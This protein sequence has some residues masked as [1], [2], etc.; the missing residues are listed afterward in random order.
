LNTNTAIVL[1]C[2][3]QDGSYLCE[4][5]ISKGFNVIGVDQSVERSNLR[6]FQYNKIDLLEDGSLENLLNFSKP[7]QIYNLAGIT[8]LIECENDPLKAFR[9][10]T[11]LV[12]RIL[13]FI[14]NIQP[15]TRFFQAS[16]S[17]IF[18]S[19]S[20]Q[21]PQNETTICKPQNIYAVTKLSSHEAV[22]TFRDNY[23][24]K[25][26]SG[27]LYNHESSRRKGGF[28]TKK[29]CDWVL[30]HSKGITQEPLKLGNLD[31]V[32]DFGH[33]RDFVK[34]MWMMLNQNDV[35][36]DFVIGTGVLTSIKSFVSLAFKRIHIDIKWEVQN[37]RNYSGEVVKVYNGFDH[38]GSLL[39]SYDLDYW[40]P[41]K[42]VD[43]V[44]DITKIKK[45]L[46]WKPKLG[47]C[48]LIDDM[49]GVEGL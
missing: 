30:L 11:F 19:E 29:V 18:G 45:K 41:K 17:E 46:N 22:K 12:I 34:A 35:T 20:S 28:L 37:I 42:Q 40:R 1:G 43:I 38:D 15:Q 7:D 23:N 31:D 13:E 14:K 36:D 33:A 27:I 5:L 2:N 25:C 32:R 4:L 3:G 21:C 6:L 47:L 26:C 16:S 44:A 49:L 8:N 39:V 48:D 24:L 10:N 9:L